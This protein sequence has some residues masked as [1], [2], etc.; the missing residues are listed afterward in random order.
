MLRRTK[1]DQVCRVYTRLFE[2]YPDIQSIA[3]A[4]QSD[5]K[6]IVRPLGLNWRLPAF[7]L[8]ARAIRDR[9]A[10]M[11][12][13]ERGKLLALP[14]V[15]DYVAGAVLSIACGQEEWIVDSNVVRLFKRY[16]GVETSKEGRRD[17]HIIEIAQAYVKGTDARKANLALLDFSALVCAPRSQCGGKC[18][19]KRTC[20]YVRYSP[21]SRQKMGFLKVD[22]S[23]SSVR[24]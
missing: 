10:C 9:F 8:V 12:P 20:Y 4:R 21:S 18:P 11:V 5:L 6:R 14:G 15:G 24:L 2:K 19:L 3:R 7:R 17:R 23:P 13:R 22:S 1:A 16:F